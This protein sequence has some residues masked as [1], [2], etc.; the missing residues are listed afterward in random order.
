MTKSN[1]PATIHTRAWLTA[2]LLPTA[3][4]RDHV[5]SGLSDHIFQLQKAVNLLH[6]AMNRL[7]WVVSPLQR[8]PNV[9]R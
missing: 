5:V 1:E 7:R 6:G 9:R 8:T 3:I 2:T 4:T